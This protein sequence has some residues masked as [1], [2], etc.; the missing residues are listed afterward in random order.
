M[1]HIVAVLFAS[2]LFAPPALAQGRADFSGAWEMDVTRSES[3]HAFGFLGPVMLVIHQTDTELTKSVTRA[4]ETETFTYAL[5]GSESEDAGGAVTSRALW[6]G[7]KLVLLSTRYESDVAL[8]SR[9]TFSLER[10]GQ[11]LTIETSTVVEH[12]YSAAGFKDVYTRSR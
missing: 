2:V 11:E 8:T 4:D 6:Q 12:A 9:E 7:E 10:A 5:D 3:A 1:R